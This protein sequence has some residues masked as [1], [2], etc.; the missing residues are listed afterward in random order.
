[1][2][3]AA[4]VAFA[5]LAAAMLVADDAKWKDPDITWAVLSQWSREVCIDAGL[6]DKEWMTLAKEK[7]G[8]RLATRPTPKEME[9]HSR[10]IYGGVSF[11]EFS[12]AMAV[13]ET[14]V[15]LHETGVRTVTFKTL[16]GQLA[17]DGYKGKLTRP[18]WA[19]G[20]SCA[21]IPRTLRPAFAVRGTATLIDVAKILTDDTDPNHPQFTLEWYGHRHLLT[22]EEVGGEKAK[23]AKIF[24]LGNGR[25]VAMLI[26]DSVDCD[27]AYTLMDLRGAN[28]KLILASNWDCET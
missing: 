10:E 12:A 19:Q 7:L 24:R 21:P 23:D 3:Q 8:N 1:L 17:A 4:A 16:R 2:R 18:T 20:S 9:S 14:L 15:L 25:R 27:G 11:F 5:L 28:A 22:R 6:T 13:P 26:W